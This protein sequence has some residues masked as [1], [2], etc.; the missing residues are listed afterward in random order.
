MFRIFTTQDFDKRFEKLDA[1][2]QKE[3]D[4]EIEQL[5]E[6]PSVGKPLGYPFFREKKVRNRRLYYLATRSN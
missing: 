1:Q 2:L 3:I 6:N 5:K 4:Q